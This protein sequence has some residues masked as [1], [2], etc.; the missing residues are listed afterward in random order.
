MG[1]RIIGCNIPSV[2]TLNILSCSSKM[3]KRATLLAKFKMWN[4][5]SCIIVIYAVAKAL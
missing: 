4:N 2:W 3:K 5:G 1:F